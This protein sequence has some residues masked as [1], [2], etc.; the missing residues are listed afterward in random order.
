MIN[1]SDLI[2]LDKS[3]N[4]P[5]YLQLTNEIIR[6][7]QSGQLRKGLKL[8]GSRRLSDQLGIN[9]MTVVAAFDELQAQGWIDQKAR[10]GS[11]VLEELPVLTPRSILETRSKLTGTKTIPFEINNTLLPVPQ[12]KAIEGRQLVIDDGFPDPRLAPL[13]EL[14]RSMRGLS[15]IPTYKKYLLYSDTRGNQML[16]EILANFLNDTR[17]LPVTANNLLLTRGAIMG[18]YLAARVITQPGNHII[19]SEPG[20]R[21]SREMFLQLQLNIHTV[22][23]DEYGLDIEKVERICM[24]KDIRFVYTVPHHH[25][26]TT[27]TLSPERRI[28]LLELAKHYNFAIIE[29]DYDYDFHF[30]SKPMMPMA[31]IDRNGNVIYVG[32]LTKTLA[33]AIRIGFLTATEKFVDY[34]TSYRRLIDFQGDTFLE[35]A[36]AELYRDGIIEKCI[37]KSLEIYKNRRDY[38][39]ELLRT[40]FKEKVSFNIPNGGMSVWT[41]FNGIDLQK[42]SEAVSKKGL[43]ISD[44]TKYD[45]KE[46]KYNS[47]RMGF[48]SL[49]ISEQE[50]AIEILKSCIEQCLKE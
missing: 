48:A 44:G 22:P 16:R 35:L 26:P 31:S 14:T 41:K 5:I 2:K 13:E 4:T 15:K 40:R 24:S 7:I 29:D 8:P 38:F 32:T 17:G 20:F 34:A 50:E 3:S 23:V 45:S 25:Y 11:F 49:N 10:K 43:L 1:F 21:F 39:C 9:R 19:M 37:K 28:R 30:A 18:I 33:P 36:I 42:L 6:Q 27:V 47:I 12:L 46:V